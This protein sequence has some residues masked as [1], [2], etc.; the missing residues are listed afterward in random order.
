MISGRTIKLAKGAVS[1]FNTLSIRLR[2]HI[3]FNGECFFSINQLNCSYVNSKR[4]FQKKTKESKYLND[5][6][7]LVRS[8]PATSLSISQELNRSE[9]KDNKYFMWSIFNVILSYLII[10]NVSIKAI[11]FVFCYSIN[12]KKYQEICFLTRIKYPISEKKSRF[13]ISR[14]YLAQFSGILTCLRKHLAW[15]LLSTLTRR[16][17]T[18]FFFIRCKC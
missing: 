17:S 18:P 11:E 9:G 6:G 16:I 3:S 7:V 12:V 10:F 4:F 1:I 14:D 5:P 13:N 2:S 8:Q 15:A